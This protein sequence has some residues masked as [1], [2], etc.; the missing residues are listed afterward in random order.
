MTESQIAAAM[1]ALAEENG[2][3]IVSLALANHA[4]FE[5]CGPIGFNDDPHG[6]K[7]LEHSWYESMRHSIR[8]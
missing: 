6:F 2:Y 3:Q 5:F 7:S 4:G 1:R 8:R